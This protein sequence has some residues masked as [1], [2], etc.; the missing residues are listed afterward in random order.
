MSLRDA[1]QCTF[2]FPVM[3][4]TTFW[5][6][7]MYAVL[8]QQWRQPMHEH[9]TNSDELDERELNEVVGGL[10]DAQTGSGGEYPAGSPV[11][12]VLP[13]LSAQLHFHKFS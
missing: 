1:Q 5:R 2:G 13:S 4:I 7:H 8:H 12:F 9:L 11:P 10:T 3:P 6:G